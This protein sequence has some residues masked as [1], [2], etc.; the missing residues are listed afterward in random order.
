MQENEYLVT[1]VLIMFGY[2]LKYYINL[3]KKEE[4]YK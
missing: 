4:N 1:Q 2:W 3:K